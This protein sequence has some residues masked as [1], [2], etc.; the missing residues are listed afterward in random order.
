MHFLADSEFGLA[1]V[2]VCCIK[3]TL[4][5]ACS[6]AVVAALRRASSAVR[7]HVWA[8]AILAMLLLPLLAVLLPSWHSFVLGG[9]AAFWSTPHRGEPNLAA[10]TIPATIVHVTPGSF[11][12]PTW[13]SASAFLWAFGAL[14][15]LFRLIVGL[16]R[17]TWL[18]ARATPLFEDEWMRE[19]L[20]ISAALK[21]GRSVR[22]LECSEA[23]AMPLT[24]GIFHPVIVLPAGAANWPNERRRIVLSHELAHIARHDW[25]LQICAELA[26]S[27]HWFNPLVWLAAARLRQES[28]RACDDAVLRSGVA[29]D[30]YASQ[31]LDLA[32]TLGSSGRAWSTALAIARPTNLERRFAA[33]LNP[34]I[35]RRQVISTNKISG[36]V[37]SSCVVASTCRAS[38]V[39]T[40]PRRQNLG[41]CP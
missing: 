20:T 8:A 35:D 23:L 30:V 16:T 31:L 27:F 15:I 40:R 18:T 11:F 34:S 22:L 13:A 32:R 9:S 4:L 3:T 19:T 38:P 12:L 2:L 1:F 39:G 28:E 33:M 21:I 17:L 36:S 41:R 7:H 25:L 6:W 5:L 37:S 26:R 14:F 29:P 10:Q 24:W